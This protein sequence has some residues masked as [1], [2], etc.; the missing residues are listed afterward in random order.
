MACSANCGGGRI[1]VV[2]CAESTRA[3]LVAQPNAA[4]PGCAP[5]HVAL[6][7]WRGLHYTVFISIS[8][9]SIRGAVGSASR[10]TENEFSG[11]G[12]SSGVA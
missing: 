1:A 4:C 12:H 5:G 7:D 3:V 9:D 11:S 2:E 6:T 10:T 8:V